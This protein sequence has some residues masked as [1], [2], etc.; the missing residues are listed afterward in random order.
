MVSTGNLEKNAESLRG[1]RCTVDLDAIL[2]GVGNELSKIFVHV[3]DHIGFDSMGPG[4]A[5]LIVRDGGKGIQSSGRAAAGIVI[6]GDLQILISDGL[7][8]VGVKCFERHK[9]FKS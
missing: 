2:C 6:Q 5:L 3:R 7:A 8:D 1:I 9:V 4:A